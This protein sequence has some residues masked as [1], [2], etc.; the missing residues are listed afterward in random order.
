MGPA[1]GEPGGGGVVPHG[2]EMH[3]GELAGAAFPKAKS[4]ETA[5][6]M[7]TNLKEAW[8]EEANSVIPLE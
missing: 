3:K 6:V 5:N 8:E 1:R 2:Q 7:L 4:V